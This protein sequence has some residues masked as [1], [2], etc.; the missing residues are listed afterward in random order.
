M[1]LSNFDFVSEMEEFSTLFYSLSV[2]D[3]LNVN[4]HSLS[5]LVP[6]PEL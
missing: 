1:V 3:F 6:E 2:M 4:N 5:E